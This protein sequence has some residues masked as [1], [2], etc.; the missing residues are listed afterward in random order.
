MKDQ[1][2]CLKSQKKNIKLLDWLLQFLLNFF[3]KKIGPNLKFNI[4]E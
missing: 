2:L 3:N 1:I 4:S